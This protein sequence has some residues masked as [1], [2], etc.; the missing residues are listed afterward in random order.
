MAEIV[1]EP[2]KYRSAAYIDGSLIGLCEYV[3]QSGNWLITHTEVLPQFGGQGIARELV[4]EIAKQ[5]EANGA[6]VVPVCSYAVKV[7]GEPKKQ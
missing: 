7:L 5:A 6:N 2:G 1:Y 4:L 3:V